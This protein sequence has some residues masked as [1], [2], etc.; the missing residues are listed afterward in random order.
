VRTRGVIGC[1]HRVTYVESCDAPRD[2]AAATCTWVL[3]SGTPGSAPTLS[4]P[5]A[6]PASSPPP[7]APAPAPIPA[8]AP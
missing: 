4:P 1:G 6:V 3:N 2:S 7:P 8:S 5:D